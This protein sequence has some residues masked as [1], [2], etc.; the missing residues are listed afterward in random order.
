M[1]GARRHTLAAA[2]LAAAL[3]TTLP[4]TPAGALT[5]EP[6]TIERAEVARGPCTL[7]SRWRLAV[8]RVDRGL[9]VALLLRTPK[10][11]QRWNIF[12]EHDLEGIFAGSRRS[13]LEGRVVVR[14]TVPDHPDVDRFRFGANNTVTGE[15]CRGRVSA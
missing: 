2:T 15:T 9:R 4:A 6:V 1:R 11:D 12:I 8:R 5:A 13:D 14:R 7:A 10:P 3:A